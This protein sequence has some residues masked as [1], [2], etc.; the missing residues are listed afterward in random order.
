MISTPRRKRVLAFA[1]LAVCSACKPDTGSILSFVGSDEQ[2][3]PAR[4]YPD[5]EM[6]ITLWKRGGGSDQISI[7]IAPDRRVQV[8]KYHVDW[9]SEEPT[10][11]TQ[12]LD[13]KRLRDATF[14]QLRRRLSN[15]RPPVLGRPGST[16][17]PRG[18]GFFIHG[19]GAV[20][21]GFRD[22]EGRTGDFVLQEDC[23][24]FGA[25]MVERDLVE[26]LKRLPP[27]RGTQGYGRFD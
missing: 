21:V 13:V 1:L 4:I 14:T 6:S 11:V 20:N 22:P 5:E 3:P 12:I 2:L 18:C 26:L 17:L 10:V 23:D 15:Y 24:T 25:K 27:L 8:K 7:V 19:Q 9:L 16:M